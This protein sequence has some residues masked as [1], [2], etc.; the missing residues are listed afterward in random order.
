MRERTVTISSTRQDLQPHGLEDRLHLRR[1]CAHRGAAH[2][3]HQFVTFAIAS[4]FQHA[5]A[6]AALSAGDAYFRELRADYRS[7][8]DRLC[9]GPARR[10]LR[11]C[12]APEGTYFA[13]ADIRPLGYE[14]GATF[15]RELVREGRRG[16]DP[17]VRL[18]APPAPARH[19]VRFAFCKKDATLDEGLRR[20]ARLKG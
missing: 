12:G 7:R 14:D 5:I 20:L 18:L 2:A 13:L 10:G 3:V 11:A 1:A 19:L 6:A 4:P 8:R 9:D 15:C 17:R 16:G